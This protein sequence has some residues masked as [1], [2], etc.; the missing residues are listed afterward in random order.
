[1]FYIT[2]LAFFLCLAAPFGLFAEHDWPQWRGP[3]RDGGWRETGLRT[4]LEMDA[5]GW[6]QL[7]WSAEVAAGYSQPTVADGRVYVS[8]RLDDPDEIERVHCFDF[9]TGETLWSHQYPAAYTIAYKSGPRAAVLLDP[10]TTGPARA[11]SLGGV[12]HLHCLDAQTGEVIWKR[13]LAGEYQ[14]EMPRWGIAAS[15]LSISVPARNAGGPSTT[16]PVMSRPL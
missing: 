12:G 7:K 3:E 15:P 6:I 10:S 8:D 13:D 2:R 16:M 11:Y 5:E 14:I 1:M 4:E 9:E